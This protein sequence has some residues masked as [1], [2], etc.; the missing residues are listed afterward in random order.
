[1]WSDQV[2]MLRVWDGKDD[3]FAAVFRPASAVEMLNRMDEDGVLC[4]S[5]D[6]TVSSVVVSISDDVQF[7][8]P[9]SL[10]LVSKWFAGASDA[11]RRLQEA[12][13]EEFDDEFDDD[14][15]GDF[16]DEL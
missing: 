13:L 11:L 14:L 16:Y 7:T 8:T 3:C 5:C 4:P 12:E 2:L 15:S 1:M 10:S 6:N 9:E